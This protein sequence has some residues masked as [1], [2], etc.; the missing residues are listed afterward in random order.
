MHNSKKT[1]IIL[2]RNVKFNNH[3]D[4]LIYRKYLDNNQGYFKYKAQ[5]FN[6][7][8]IN[9]NVDLIFVNWD[10]IIISLYRDFSTNKFTN[11]HKEAKFCYIL[12]VDTIKKNKFNI[13]DALNHQRLKKKET[14][15]YNKI[16]QS[17]Y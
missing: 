2:K 14:K 13:G 11:F 1:K 15:K 5:G 12:P 17:F 9:F 16:D 6:S 8:F 10:N 7:L 3:L 4:N